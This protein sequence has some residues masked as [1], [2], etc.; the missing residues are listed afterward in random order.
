MQTAMTLIRPSLL[1]DT[2]AFAKKWLITFLNG[3]A[4]GSSVGGKL[5][6]SVDR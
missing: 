2:L 3:L 6:L 4:I 1:L 5:L